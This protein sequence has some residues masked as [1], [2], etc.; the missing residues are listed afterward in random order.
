MERWL[1]LAEAFPDVPPHLRTLMALLQAA[2]AVV[3]LGRAM[4]EKRDRNRADSEELALRVAILCGRADAYRRDVDP[5]GWAQL[6]QGWAKQE[7][8]A[9]N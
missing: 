2:G 6:V 9:L 5:Q 4:A 3:D 7:T 8:A 1:T